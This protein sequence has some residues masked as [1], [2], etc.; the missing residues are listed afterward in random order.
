MEYFD[1][2]YDFDGLK[3]TFDNYVLKKDSNG[4]FYA[5]KKGDN[6]IKY[7]G[8]IVDR[9][10][11]SYSW[12]QATLIKTHSRHLTNHK[13][14]DDLD[15]EYAFNNDSRKVFDIMMNVI[16]VE[17]EKTGNIN[18]YEIISEFDHINNFY[19]NIYEDDNYKYYSIQ[20]VKNLFSRKTFFDLTDKWA[21][22]AYKGAKNSN[23]GYELFS[24]EEYNSRIR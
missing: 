8:S 10:R 13:E 7:V 9:L 4:E 5:L 21:R 19:P 22:S 2:K 20:I 18:P 16:R 14:M 11:F 23:K 17:L 6:K 3:Y 15:Y 1:H 12:A 24:E